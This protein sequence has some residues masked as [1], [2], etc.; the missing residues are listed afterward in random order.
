MESATLSNSG[1]TK[2]TRNIVMRPM[3][4]LTLRAISS[5]SS[6]WAVRLALGISPMTKPSA[7]PQPI[8]PG[9]VSEVGP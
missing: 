4:I 1:L 6:N 5:T 7:M 9:S 8:W 2:E 3:G